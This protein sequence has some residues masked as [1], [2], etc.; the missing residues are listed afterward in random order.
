MELVI[1]EFSE[2]T[3]EELFKIYKLRVSVFVVEQQCPY[4]EVDDF[5]TRSIHL[6]YLE[7]GEIQAYLRILPKGTAFPE[8]SLGRV[9][10]VKRRCGL[11]SKI[12][13]KGI[14]I[15]R[16]RLNADIITI[17]AQTYARRLYED[18][19]FVQTSDE[20]LEDGIPHIQMKLY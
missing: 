12:V 14:E 11:G 5:D 1:K 3:T 15:A 4:Q 19:G 17:E 10:A 7:N 13:G 8:V 6:F 9:I 20:F 18:F 2:L 16:E